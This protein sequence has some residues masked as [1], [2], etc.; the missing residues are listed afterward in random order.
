MKA[1]HHLLAL[2]YEGV[3]IIFNLHAIELVARDVAALQPPLSAGAENGHT[4]IPPAVNPAGPSTMKRGEGASGV[5]YCIQFSYASMASGSLLGVISAPSARHRLGGAIGWRSDQCKGQEGRAGTG[6][7]P[8]PDSPFARFAD[9]RFA[10][11]SHLDAKTVGFAPS[12]ISIPMPPLPHRL[13]RSSRPLVSAPRM[14]TPQLCM[15]RILRNCENTGGGWGGGERAR[16]DCLGYRSPDYTM[17]DL[18]A[19]FAMYM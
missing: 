5:K 19:R 11:P 8:I 10:P 7:A 12:F 1:G 16:G 14:E 15:L 6:P 4:I 9:T 13:Q 2:S 17:I 18:H 3:G